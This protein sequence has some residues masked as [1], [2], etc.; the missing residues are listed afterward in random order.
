MKIMTF[1]TLHCLN[2][3][4][5]KI[6]F[7]LFA[8]T[9]KESDADVIG[10]NEIRDKGED[11]DYEAQMSILSELSGY[12]NYYFARAIY[13]H[14]KKNPYG[15]GLLSK[16]KILSV[17]NIPIPDPEGRV[18]GKRYETRCI[19]KARL[20]GGVTVLV[21][22]FGLNPDE[23]VNAVSTVMENLEDEK[24]IL[25]GDFNMTPDNK[26][27]APIQNKM[28]DTASLFTEPKASFPSDKPEI[29]IDY[30][31]VSPDVEV[32]SANIPALVVSD[33]LPHVAEIKI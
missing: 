11:P 31:F 28:K 2:Y 27:L 33:H 12:E 13:V 3:L 30:I 7:P 29:K 4:E 21:T 19:L 22:H 15:N 14:G 24:C 26:I 17:E 6:D 8:K 1:N 16:K 5:N 9:I 20:E 18:A 23:M 32:I 10:L 25:M